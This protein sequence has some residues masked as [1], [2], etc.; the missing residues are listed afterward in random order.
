MLLLLLV[1][2]LPI[3]ELIKNGFT[4]VLYFFSA[5]KNHTFPFGIFRTRSY[6][7][8]TIHFRI[9]LG[10]YSPA[11][12]DFLPLCY[13]RILITFITTTTTTLLFTIYFFTATFSMLL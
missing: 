12:V 11:R 8:Y 10:I 4:F 1:L 3:C 5:F 6:F 7:F 13:F 9:L 2:I